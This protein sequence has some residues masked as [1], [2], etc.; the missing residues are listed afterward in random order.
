[1]KK[2]FYIFLLSFCSLAFNAYASSG[3]LS[4]DIWY[5]KSSFGDGDSVYIHT[6]VWNESSESVSGTVQFFD[7]NVL[8]GKRDITIEKQSLKDVSILWKVTAGDHKISAKFTGDIASSTKDSLEA[9]DESI[10]I[11]KKL[12]TSS[13]DKALPSAVVKDKIGEVLPKSVAEPVSNS[14][15]SLDTFR[16]DTFEKLSSIYEDTNKKIEAFSNTITKEKGKSVPENSSVESTTSVSGVEKPLA[17]VELFLVG[18]A[19][20][21]FNQTVLF[22][23]ILALL[24]FV[25]LRFIYRKIRR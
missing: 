24:S 8:L 15:A 12:D 18:I 14:F 19:K 11:A 25:I 16:T 20:F 3:F 7:K 6:A 5:S 21:I 23:V 13:G 22:Y 9:E 17:Y 2:F 10:F 1:M 4:D